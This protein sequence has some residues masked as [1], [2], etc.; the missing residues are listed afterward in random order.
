MNDDKKT[1]SKMI[2]IYCRSKHGSG[3][4]L[5]DDC[6]DL[7]RYAFDRLEHCRYGEEKPVCKKC[8]VHCYKKDMRRYIQDVM[9]FSG[10][11]MIFYSP[12]SAFGHFM[13]GLKTKRG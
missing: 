11:H 5:C 10:P 9:R 2:R 8:P 1:I 3:D 6:A 13:K 12:K 7:E 4:T